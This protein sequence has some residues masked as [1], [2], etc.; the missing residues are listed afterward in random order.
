MG[1]FLRL[2]YKTLAQGKH[3]TKFN[4]LNNLQNNK[5]SVFS[6]EA[7]CEDFGLSYLIMES[8]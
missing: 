1:E 6:S 5:G 8:E 2:T 4:F 3:S 7:G